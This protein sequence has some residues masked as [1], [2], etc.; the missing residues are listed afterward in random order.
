AKFRGTASVNIEVLDFP[1]TKKRE[2]DE[3]NTKRLKELFKKAK[4]CSD[5]KLFNHIPAVIDQHQLTEAL[6][7]S[8]ISSEALLTSHDGH[9]ELDFPTGFRLCCLRGQ[10]RALAAKEVLPAGSRR[11]TV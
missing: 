4:G 9:I 1:C 8:G 5:W 10:H 6:A 11:W 2:K 7:R 3:K